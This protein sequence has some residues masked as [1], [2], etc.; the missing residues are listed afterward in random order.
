MPLTFEK[1]KGDL[2]K[3]LWSVRKFSDL[4]AIY[5]EAWA[6]TSVDNRIGALRNFFSSM[7]L[8]VLSALASSVAEM[9]PVMSVVALV[10]LIFGLHEGIRYQDLQDKLK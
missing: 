6:D 10:C 9:A 4:I 2:M 8:F 3:P 1:I 7:A 5:T